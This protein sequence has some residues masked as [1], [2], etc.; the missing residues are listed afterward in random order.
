V[1]SRQRHNNMIKYKCTISTILE[2]VLLQWVPLLMNI[3][4]GWEIQQWNITGG[5]RQPSYKGIQSPFGSLAK[6][7]PDQSQQCNGI[8]TVS[9]ATKNECLKNSE[10][11]A[12]PTI[13]VLYHMN[14]QKL[15]KSRWLQ[16]VCFTMLSSTTLN[17]FHPC[18]TRKETRQNTVQLY[19]YIHSLHTYTEH[20]T[21]V[22][23]SSLILWFVKYQGPCL[24]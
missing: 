7:F 10:H 6:T 11:L 17:V 22:R 21:K 14:W 19:W 20:Y 13:Q 8:K 3:S 15:V 18:F 24:S 16:L 2:C 5:C 1:K 4:L 12:T 23:V 9:L